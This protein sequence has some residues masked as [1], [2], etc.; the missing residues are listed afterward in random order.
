MTDEQTAAAI[1]ADPMNAVSE[2]AM[3]AAIVRALQAART[4][5]P[6]HI[7]DDAGVVRK[8]DGRLPINKDGGVSGHGAV[9]SFGGDNYRMVMD[10]LPETFSWNTNVCVSWGGP[11]HGAELLSD[12]HSVPEAAEAAK[13]GKA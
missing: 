6:G 13:E 5:P 9:V 4:P 1:V 11:N 3:E 12:C 7:I 8:V 10:C 2:T